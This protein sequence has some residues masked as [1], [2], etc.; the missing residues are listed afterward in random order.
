MDTITYI[1]RCMTHNSFVLYHKL[2]WLFYQTF[3]LIEYSYK[4][5]FKGVSTVEFHIEKFKLELTVP[6]EEQALL[7][8]LVGTSILKR[9]DYPEPLH[10]LFDSRSFHNFFFDKYRINLVYA[11]GK[12]KTGADIIEYLALAGISSS[13]L[14]ARIG[15][16]SFERVVT[17]PS[18]SEAFDRMSYLDDPSR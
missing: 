14:K 13:E 6:G 12:I 15:A 9:G 16:I 8:A 5:V 10:T 3:D 2:F 17:A 7:L 4:R 1:F 11:F 18:V